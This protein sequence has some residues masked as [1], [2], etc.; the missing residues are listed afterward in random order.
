MLED[1]ASD[2][3]SVGFRPLDGER[4]EDGVGD[5]AGWAH[6]DVEVDDVESAG[7]VRGLGGKEGWRVRWVSVDLERVEM[8]VEA[9]KR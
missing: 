4:V 1:L 9:M 2:P 3:M 6:A 7:V 5:G 8:V